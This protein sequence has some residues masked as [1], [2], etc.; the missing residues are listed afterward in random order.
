MMSNSVSLEESAQD[1]EG[2]LE[3]SSLKMIKAEKSF[4]NTAR[5]IAEVVDELSG[6][7][8][9]VPED[10]NGAEDDDKEEGVIFRKDMMKSASITGFRERINK[11]GQNK[12]KILSNFAYLTFSQIFGERMTT[13]QDGLTDDVLRGEKKFKDLQRQIRYGRRGDKPFITYQ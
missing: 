5:I 13:Y 2:R 10:K 8:E 7:Y 6:E 9:Y 1:M 11:V 3:K 4:M 12:D